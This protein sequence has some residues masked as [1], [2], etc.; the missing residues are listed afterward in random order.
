MNVIEGFL[1]GLDKWP[2]GAICRVVLGFCIPPIFRTLVGDPDRVWMALIFFI[3]L[4]I[5]LRE[6]PAVLRRAL[7]F[8]AEAKSIWAERRN[9]AKAYDSYQWQKLF[10]IGLG[11]LSYSFI[12]GGLRNGEWVLTCICLVGGG[13]GLLFWYRINAVRA[14]KAQLDRATVSRL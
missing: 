7:P 2:W 13:A 4:L 3:A 14:A 5:A 1:V 12:G 9:T 10:W 11:L 6:I 8:S